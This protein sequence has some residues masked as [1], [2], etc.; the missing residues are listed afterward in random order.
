MVLKVF[1]CFSSFLFQHAADISKELTKL[2]SFFYKMK[3]CNKKKTLWLHFHLALYFH[4]AKRKCK[5]GRE[6][7]CPCTRN[8]YTNTTNITWS[9]KWDWIQFNIRLVSWNLVATPM[10][11]VCS[12]RTKHPWFKYYFLKKIDHLCLPNLQKEVYNGPLQSNNLNSVNYL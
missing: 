3:S 6:K 9:S 12:N 5:K 8:M 10:K 2:G 4:S 7:S 11:Q 1:T